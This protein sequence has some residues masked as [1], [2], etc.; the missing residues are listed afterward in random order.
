MKGSPRSE[1]ELLEMISAVLPKP[2]GDVLTGIGDDCAVIRPTGR[3]DPLEL[4]KTDALVE[5]VHFVTG[6]PLEKVGWK[7]LCRPLS[8]IA[9]MGGTPRHAVITVAAPSS[10]GLRD[11]RALYR[12]LGKASRQ[13]D[14][15]VI[16]GETVRTTGPLVLS[17]TLTGS[18]PRRHLK[19]RSGGS[20]GD[21]ICVTGRLGGSFA[22]GRHLT[23]QPRMAEG[24]WLGAER[25]VSAMMDLSD[26]LGGDLPK[27]AKESGC[28]F[29]ISTGGL[30]LNRGC[31]F[32]EGISDGED[33]ELLLTVKPRSW[34]DLQG[35]WTSAHPR[36]PLTAIG[37]LLPAGEK[38]SLL[39]AGFDH[40]DPGPR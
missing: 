4:L 28:S 24:R 6:T 39:A 2:S 40:F 32:R 15:S 17:V 11:W 8:D 14:V 38:S 21:L 36:L 25:G 3:R 27:M 33:Y 22:S 16:G 30:P 20:P 10:L 13:F 7:A 29:R 37:V 9:A 23:F 26:G 1:S 34:P 18:V 35:R 31:T 5:G 12:G 19:L